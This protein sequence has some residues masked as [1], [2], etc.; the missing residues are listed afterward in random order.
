MKETAYLLQSG[1]ILAWWV[2]LVLSPEFFGAFQFDGIPPVAFWSFCVP[3]LALIAG[4][5]LLRGY[6]DRDWIGYVI[7]GAFGYGAL[8]CCNATFLTGSGALGTSL[9][10]CGL[11]YNLFLCFGGTVFRP[12][13][14]TG[15]LMNGAKTLVQVIC[16]WLVTL[17]VVPWIL[18][19]AFGGLTDA[20]AAESRISGI[21]LFVLFSLL[22]IG[23]AFFMVR[24][25][26]GTPL[27]LDQTNRLV[28]SGPYRFV[29]NPMAIAGVGQGVAIA[30]GCQSIPILVYSL[31][32][33]IV[34]QMVVRPVE[35]RDL[36]RRFGEDYCRYRERVRCWIPRW[37]G[38]RR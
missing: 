16:I 2:G 13:A 19:D 15:F 11:G 23:S 21:C 9:M 38:F 25:G 14:S 1:L 34:W 10:V 35:E 17:V 22:G 6:L 4:L 29:R 37:P 12:S 7:L 26:Q 18:L 28:V 24:D 30:V 8:Y 31:L 20:V 3:D 33:G 27:P 32:G 5:S 36:E